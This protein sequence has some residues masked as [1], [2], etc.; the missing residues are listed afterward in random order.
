MKSMKL[1]FNEL[2]LFFLLT[3]F[4]C[5]YIKN[6]LI[7]L[8]IVVFH[9]LGHVLIC[10]ILG[11]DIICI[12]IFPFGGITKISKHLNDHIYRDFLIAIFGVVFQLLLFIPVIFGFITNEVFIK[13]NLSIMLF[14]LLPIIP[15]DGS[16]IL[17]E[18][19]SRFFFI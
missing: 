15:L 17:F 10:K 18:V 16:K 8:F 4:L 3:A 13:Y 1:K 12:E 14:N 11:Y 2:T 6:A 5:G 19:F 9:E 7:I